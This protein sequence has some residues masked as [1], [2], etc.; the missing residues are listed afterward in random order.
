MFAG[1][2]D[3][4]VKKLR[5]FG[6]LV[7]LVA[8]A[9]GGWLFLEGSRCHSLGRGPTSDAAW[10]NYA[11]MAKATLYTVD[12]IGACLGFRNDSRIAHDCVCCNHYAPGDCNALVWPRPT[13]TKARQIGTIL[14]DAK[15]ASW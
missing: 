7:G 9:I 5:S 14:L 15:G 8:T 11:Q 4:S 2:L 3:T 6:L 1:Q 10:R 13:P 12:G